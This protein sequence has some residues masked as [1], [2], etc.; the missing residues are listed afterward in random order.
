MLQ[1]RV[2]VVSFEQFDLKNLG[3]SPGSLEVFKTGLMLVPFKKR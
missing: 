1:C 2:A 3:S